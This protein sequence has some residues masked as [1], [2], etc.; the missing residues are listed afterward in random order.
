M[1]AGQ[2]ANVNFLRVVMKNVVW[3]TIQQVVM[4]DNIL[5]RLVGFCSFYLKLFIKF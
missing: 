3:K 2:I 4:Y 1:N 5:A